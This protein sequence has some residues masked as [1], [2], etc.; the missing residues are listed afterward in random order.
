MSRGKYLSLEEARRAGQIDQFCKEH[1]SK[2][3]ASRFDKLFLAMARKRPT[4]DQTSVRLLPHIVA[5]LKLL[6]VRLKV[7]PGT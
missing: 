6:H 3:D 4:A 2:G 1:P 7:L 5:I